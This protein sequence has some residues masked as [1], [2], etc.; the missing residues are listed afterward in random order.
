MVVCDHFPG[1]RQD[2]IAS[3]LVVVTISQ[4]MDREGVANVLVVAI[5]RAIDIDV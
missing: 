1:S 3:V 4:A 2:C 5:F